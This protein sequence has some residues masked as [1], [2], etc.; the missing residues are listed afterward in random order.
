MSSR[1]LFHLEV[2]PDRPPNVVFRFFYSHSA[3]YWQQWMNNESHDQQ[4]CFE[5]CDDPGKILTKFNFNLWAQNLLQKMI[6]P[7]AANLILIFRGSLHQRRQ[8]SCLGHP[9]I[10]KTT[11]TNKKIQHL[12]QHQHYNGYPHQQQNR[13]NFNIS[14]SWY[15]EYSK[16]NC[17]CQ[18]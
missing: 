10:A 13:N 2:F 1:S 7:N 6:K 11:N 14:Y 16:I 15:R 9:T 5:P 12:H 4:L 17:S 18:G 3:T 8:F